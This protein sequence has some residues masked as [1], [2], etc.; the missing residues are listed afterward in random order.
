MARLQYESLW[1]ATGTS[2][3]PAQPFVVRSRAWRTLRA[4]DSDRP[5]P[6][7]RQCRPLGFRARGR[8]A[9]GQGRLCGIFRRWSLLMSRNYLDKN[10]YN[11]IVFY[12]IF[13]YRVAHGNGKHFESSR[14]SPE[15]LVHMWKWHPLL[16][17]YLLFSNH[18][19]IGR[20]TR[21]ICCF[22]FKG[23]VTVQLLL[24]RNSYL[25]FRT[26]CLSFN[27]PRHHYLD[28]TVNFKEAGSEEVS[29]FPI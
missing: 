25:Q 17:N 3:A 10:E 13:I 21:C 19:P 29:A 8:L 18:G 11:I 23:I 14:G 1:S 16:Y 26:S 12:L 20:L 24:N 22:C 4:A 7:W 6:G 28:T 9:L 2:L 27:L 5:C 15:E